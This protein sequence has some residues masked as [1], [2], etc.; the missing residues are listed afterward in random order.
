MRIVVLIAAIVLATTGLSHAHQSSV[1]HVDIAVDG[2]RATVAFTIAPQDVTAPLGLPDDATPTLDEALRP[3]VAPYV[4]AWLALA[5]GNAPCTAGDPTLGPDADRR[6]IV[7]RWTATCAR[8]IDRLRLD[9]ARFFAVDQ[10]HEAVVTVHTPGEAGKPAI[11][12]A[13]SPVVELAPG[14]TAPFLAWVGYGMDHIYGGLDHVLFVIALLL[15]VV[16]QRDAAGVWEI[17][18][19]LRAL[20]STAVIVTAFTV[21]HSL[22]LITASLGY[23]RLP[24]ALVESLIAATII[25]TAIENVVRPDVRWRFWL[26]VAFGLVHGLGFASMLEELLPPTN[27]VPPLLGFNL[28]VELG[29]LTIVAVA[30]PLAWGVARLVGGDRYRRIVLLVAGIPLVVVGIKWLSERVGV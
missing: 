25:Y 23:V 29:Q 5:L 16:L 22:S 6:F 27:V 17:R 11:V 15:V 28:G 3:A 24:S 12:R 8:D 2:P 9:F 21:A 13:T 20:R 14:D 19:P 4:Q 18:P 7:V 10:R 30:L 1:K 26:T